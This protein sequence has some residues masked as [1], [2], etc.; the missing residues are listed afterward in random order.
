MICRD[1]G[2]ATEIVT[3]Q[4]NQNAAGLITFLRIHSVMIECHA[5]GVSLEPDHDKSI[6]V[7]SPANDPKR[8]VRTPRQRIQQRTQK[9]GIVND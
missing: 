3:L 5:T 2:I 7:S 9:R 4:E 1:P 8:E 6:I